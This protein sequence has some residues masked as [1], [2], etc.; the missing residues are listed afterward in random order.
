VEEFTRL[1]QPPEDAEIDPGEREDYDLVVERTNRVHGGGGIASTYCGALLN[2]PPLAATLTRFGAL[3]RQGQLRGSYSDADRELIDIVLGV[4]LRSNAILAVHI[5]D[6]L[7]VGVRL[8][9]IEALVGGDDD[10]LLPEE[11][12]LVD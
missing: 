2:S 1:P 11:R 6:A 9:A 3:V 10:A 4:D 8:E 7:A 12:E 5:P